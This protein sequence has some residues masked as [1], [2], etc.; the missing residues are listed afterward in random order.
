MKLVILGHFLPFYPLKPQKLKFWKIKKF[1]GDIII[2]H[3]YQKS[4]YMMYGSWDTEWDRQNFLS[5][6]AIFC[7]FTTPLMIPKIK[8]LKKYEK[9]ARKC[10]P[11]TYMYSKRRSY[12]IWFQKYKVG[13]TE[14]FVILGHFLPFQPLDKMENQNFKIEENTW[15]YYHFTQV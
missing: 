7:P 9:N 14:I 13:Q 2:L 6:W 5:F 4:Q 8:I 10:Y 12:D 3:V 11:F 1:D 15:T